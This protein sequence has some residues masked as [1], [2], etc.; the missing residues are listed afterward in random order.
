ME[1]D[2]SGSSKPI[3]KYRWDEFATHTPVWTYT[4]NISLTLYIYTHL[5][6]YTLTTPFTYYLIYWG[7]SWRSG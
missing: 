1:I 5:Y 4:N 2:I 3:V 6:T 7:A